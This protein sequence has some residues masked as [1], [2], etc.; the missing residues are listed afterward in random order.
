MTNHPSAAELAAECHRLIRSI[1]RKPASIKL[2]LG[3]REALQ[4]FAD[5]KT[6]R[7]TGD[8]L[9]RPP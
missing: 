3:A 6:G 5:Y 4:R 8:R 7:S 1:E 9:A 2:L